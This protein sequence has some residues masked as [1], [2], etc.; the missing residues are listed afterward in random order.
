MFPVKIKLGSARV[1]GKDYDI[2]LYVC[3]NPKYW[4]IT[5][6]KAGRYVVVADLY[7]WGTWAQPPSGW[8]WKWLID[9]GV[10][11]VLHHP[12]AKLMLMVLL[13]WDGEN[14]SCGE[15]RNE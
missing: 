14:H 11:R 4:R 5:V 3:D 2:C 13:N 1:D 6:Y 7:R 9:P 10:Q 8:P 12:I 15:R